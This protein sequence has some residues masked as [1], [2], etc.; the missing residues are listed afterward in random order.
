MEILHYKYGELKFD[1]TYK[2]T[3]KLH[4]DLFYSF[5]FQLYSI[6]IIGFETYK[7]PCFSKSKFFDL[8]SSTYVHTETYHHNSS[9]SAKNWNFQA[10]SGLMTICNKNTCINFCFNLKVDFHEP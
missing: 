6:Q 2:I 10:H 3:M 1:I 7:S 5:L 8:V 4:G 9:L